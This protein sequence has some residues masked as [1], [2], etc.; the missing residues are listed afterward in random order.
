MPTI[1]S[2]SISKIHALP[3]AGK[4]KEVQARWHNIRSYYGKEL[5]KCLKAR[6][7]AGADDIYRSKWAFFTTLDA[8][9]RPTVKSKTT[10]S[11]LVSFRNRLSIANA[12]VHLY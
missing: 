10:K 9:L 3:L 2:R 7:G 6:S 4:E 5:G 12:P 11:N 1:I 8:F